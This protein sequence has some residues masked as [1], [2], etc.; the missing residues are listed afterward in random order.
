MKIEELK[1]S[2][3]KTENRYKILELSYYNLKKRNEELESITGDGDFSYTHPLRKN[4][5]Q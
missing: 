1:A 2:T 3:T 5:Y 4:S